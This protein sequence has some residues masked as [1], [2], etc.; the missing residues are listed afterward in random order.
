M[1]K[2][3]VFIFVLLINNNLTILAN[4]E[5][6]DNKAIT[7]ENNKEIT[8]ENN[9]EQKDKNGFPSAEAILKENIK[10]DFNILSYKFKQVLDKENLEKN[11]LM[12]EN[13]NIIFSNNMI[14][15]AGLKITTPLYQKS[16]TYNLIIDLNDRTMFYN[17]LF[18]NNTYDNHEEI[19]I[20]LMCEEE[21]EYDYQINYVDSNVKNFKLRL[22]RVNNY[23][24]RIKNDSYL[25]LLDNLN[26]ASLLSITTNGIMGKDI[27]NFYV[28]Y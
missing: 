2:L 15:N 16:L 5:N 17:T 4:N 23:T 12:S 20:P 26:Y 25:E 6:V 9:V 3:M 1:K 10:T 8:K 14:V 7:K 13:Q 28:K 18:A 22:E 11:I 21:C 27:F 19:K 24:L